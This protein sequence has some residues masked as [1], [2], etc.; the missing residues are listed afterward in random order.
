MAVGATA[1]VTP[2]PILVACA[3]R[4]GA[5]TVAPVPNAMD[6][7]HVLPV[8][9]FAQTGASLLQSSALSQACPAP[10]RATHVPPTQRSDSLH[11]C[12]SLHD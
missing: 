5:Q 1:R 4:Y 6:A 2:V 10:S 8:P 11:G 9:V 7:T 12:T 3:Q